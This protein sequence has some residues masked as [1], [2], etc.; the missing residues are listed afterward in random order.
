[1]NVKRLL[2]L[3]LATVLVGALF[4]A[5]ERPAPASAADMSLFDAGNIISDAVFFDGSAMSGGAVQTF[6]N[7]RVPQCRSGATCLKD[8]RQDTQSRPATAGRCGAYAGRSGESAAEIISRVG[9]ACGVSQK[10]LLVLLEKEMGLVTSTNPSSN[11]YRIATGF[12]CPDTAACDT[13][14]YGFFNQVYSAA[15]QFKTYAA[16]PNSFSHVAGRTN[17]VRFHPN[18]GCGTSPVFIQNQATAGLYNYTPYQPNGAALAANTG[19]GDSCSSYGNRNFWGFFSNWFGSPTSGT[20]LLRTSTDG[21][22]YLVSGTVKHPIS[23][24]SVLNALSPLGTV[25]FVSDAYLGKFTAAH[26]VGRAIRNPQGTIFFIDSGIKLPFVSCGQAADY[27]SSCAADG[28]VQLTDAQ[29]NAFANGPTLSSVLGTTAGSRYYIKDGNKAEILDS[30]SQSAAGI[31][32]RMNVLSEQAVETLRLVPPVVRSGV[33]AR[34]RLTSNSWMLAGGNRLAVARSSEVALDI[35]PRVAGD[36]SSA[37]LLLIPESQPGFTGL[38]RSAPGAA[39]QMVSQAGRFA[40]V[41]TAAG[42]DRVA[43]SVPQS[44]ID[45]YPQRGEIGVG[46]FIKSEDRA[47]VFVVMPTDIRPISGWGALL[48]LT[49]SGE[50]VIQT[51][52]RSVIDVLPQGPVALTSGSLVR[53]PDDATVYL[54]NGVTDRVAMSSLEYAHEAG[55]SEL[56]FSTESRIQAYPKQGTNMTFGMT[57]GTDR[58]VAA[59]GQLHK[60]APNLHALYPFA[61]LPMDQFTCAQFDL[62]ADA[63]QFIRTPDGSIY[64]LVSGQKRPIVSAVRLRELTSTDNWLNVVDLFAAQIPTGPN[65]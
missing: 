32:D 54:V 10:A 1:M 26:A 35:R 9:A 14:F 52:P 22:V 2:G 34:S 53:S 29:A 13:S 27:A 56:T 40:V 47:D 38:V 21:T 17:N 62:G 63:T 57:C 16:Y 3:C 48:A 15:A 46:S 6:L 8:Y 31:G 65:A 28:Y 61:P 36:L 11:S 24:I 20:S 33:F 49:P 41:G 55:F 4:T 58:F 39:V 37:S 5:A 7:Q 50:P 25:G 64:H 30:V 18:A 51:V 44:L 59:G 12:G 43:A 45:S 60:V 42:A 19:L 23:S